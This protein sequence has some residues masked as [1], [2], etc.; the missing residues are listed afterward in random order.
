MKRQALVRFAALIGVMGLLATAC[1][2]DGETGN[3]DNTGDP[4]RAADSDS[5]AEAGEAGEM[6]EMGDSGTSGQEEAPTD[7]VPVQV[8]NPY[9]GET[10]EILIPFSEGSST[11]AWGQA[12]APYLEK[13]LADD[14]SVVVYN[15]G[16][17]AAAVTLYEQATDHDG[18]TVFVSSNATS[19]PFLF[20]SDEVD[21][22]FADFVAVI[23]SPVGGVVY[24]STETGVTDAAGLCDYTGEL[25]MSASSQAGLGAVPV[26]ALNLLGIEPTIV[27]DPDDA[28]NAGSIRDDFEDGDFNLSYDVSPAKDAV[29]TLFDD[30]L[31]VPLFTFGIPQSDGSL[32]P[33]PSWPDLPTIADTYEVCSGEA[34]TGGEWS[35]FEALNTAGFAAQKN[36]WVHAD[37]PPEHIEALQAAAVEILADEEFQALAEGLIGQYDFVAAAEL[38]RQFQ[39]V[40]QVTPAARTYLCEILAVPDCT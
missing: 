36:I 39:P 28:N 19:F 16:G 29:Q 13:H 1:G 32:G 18:L 10:L 15:D 14:A 17:E 11:D 4:E 2:S 37:A 5:A 33:D 35:A 3:T 9:E 25:S 20:G 30:E 12:L 24:V 21:Y 26:V 27:G 22:D 31:A 34:P 40:S 6:G 23:G 8:G 7:T 38:D